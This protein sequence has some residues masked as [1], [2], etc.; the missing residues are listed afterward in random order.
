MNSLTPALRSLTAA[1]VCEQV[2]VRHALHRAVD[3]VLSLRCLPS[4]PLLRL[5]ERVGLRGYV[6][7]Q[8]AQPLDETPDL[9]ERVDANTEDVQHGPGELQSGGAGC[10][11]DGFYFAKKP[12]IT[13]PPHTPE[14]RLLQWHT[15][16]ALR[17]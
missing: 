3:D 8:K 4:L 2:R 10:I 9:V 6:H 5:G 13:P 7:H 11:R 15:C 16:C 1:N 17:V 14:S 12:F